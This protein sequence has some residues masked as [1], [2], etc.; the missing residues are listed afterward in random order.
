MRAGRGVWITINP[1]AEGTQAIAHGDLEYEIPSVG[2]DEIGQLVNSF[3]RMTGDLRASQT[4]LE[5]RRVYTETLLR[6]VS[7]GV[8]GL[9]RLGGVTAINAYAEPILG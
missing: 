7:A 8:V 9:D 1:L 5:R 2:D 4:E 3:N 6:N